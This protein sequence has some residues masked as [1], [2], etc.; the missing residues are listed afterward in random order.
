V[1]LNARVS[2]LYKLNK[3][4]KWRVAGVARYMSRVTLFVT[5]ATFLVGSDFT[6]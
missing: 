2:K 4:P 5:C 1:G 3:T 6:Y